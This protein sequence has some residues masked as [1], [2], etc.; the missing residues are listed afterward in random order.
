MCMSWFLHLLAF[1]CLNFSANPFLFVFLIPASLVDFFLCL[2]RS[3]CH[4]MY[5]GDSYL[6][7]SV[8]AVSAGKKPGTY[9]EEMRWQLS[10][11]KEQAAL[12]KPLLIHWDWPIYFTSSKH[13]KP[14][15]ALVGESRSR[16]RKKNVNTEE[17]VSV[18][19]FAFFL[20]RK[21]PLVCLFSYVWSAALAFC[22]LPTSSPAACL[23]PC[24]PACFPGQEKP[25]APSPLCSH[26][27]YTHSASSALL[28]NEFHMALQAAVSA[29]P[30]EEQSGQVY[31]HTHWT[32][33]H[34]HRVRRVQRSLSA[35]LENT[36]VWKWPLAQSKHPLLS[37]L[38]AVC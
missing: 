30:A 36:T 21:Y 5:S 4:S 22:L 17:K 20:E 33:I 9:A 6:W 38:A 15:S 12:L 23:P 34:T 16:W 28:L 3:H 26:V 25:S 11:G 10:R 14:Y 13:K 35:D 27:P 19:I 18:C 37:S 8:H 2:H 24:L 32:K 1:C 7:L 29:R 31:A